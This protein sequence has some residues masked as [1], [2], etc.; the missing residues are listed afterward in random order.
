MNISFSGRTLLQGVVVVISD[1][2]VKHHH[3]FCP[4]THF[5]L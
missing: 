5:I 1:G 3:I 4:Q 2:A